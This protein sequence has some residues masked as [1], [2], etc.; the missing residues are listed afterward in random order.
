MDIRVEKDPDPRDVSILDERIWA[1]TIDAARVGEDVELAAFVRD[2]GEVRAGIYGWTWG[3]TCE[4]QSLWVA[5]NLRR[6]GVGDRLLAVAEAEA[7]AR[8]CRQ[9]VF[10]THQLQAPEYYEKRGYEIVGRV[11]GYPAGTAALWFVKKLG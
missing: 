8:G 10:F 3:G 6:Q 1:E 11:D 2:G 5:P 9:V 4:L 7:A